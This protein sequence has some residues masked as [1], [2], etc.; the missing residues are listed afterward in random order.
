AL[1]LTG[2]TLA[3]LHHAAPSAA[4]RTELAALVAADLAVALLRSP[5]LRTGAARAA[6]RRRRTGA[7]AR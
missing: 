3:A 7:A 6:F 5:F 4:H 2:G 1:L